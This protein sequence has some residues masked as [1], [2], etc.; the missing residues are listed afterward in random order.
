MRTMGNQPGHP[1]QSGTGR[2]SPR[3]TRAAKDSFVTLLGGNGESI[4]RNRSIE[5]REVR[6]LDLN[7]N[8]GECLP[9]HT[10]SRLR[11]TMLARESFD[12]SGARRARGA[13]S[14][15]RVGNPICPLRAFLACL[16]LHAPRSVRLADFFGVLLGHWSGKDNYPRRIDGFLEM[17]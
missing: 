13:R 14:V 17:S 6:W 8:A 12:G 11:K 9:G 1:Q 3:W 2:K 5:R 4:E 15:K 7:M 10:L 16:A